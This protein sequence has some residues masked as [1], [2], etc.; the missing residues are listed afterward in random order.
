MIE[1]KDKPWTSYIDQIKLLESR[2]MIITDFDKAITYL[3]RIGY[4]RLSGYW[5]VFLEDESDNF[6]DK[7]SFKDVIS[8]YIFDKKLRLLILDALERIEISLRSEVSYMLGEFSPY[9]HLEEEYLTD[10]FTIKNLDKTNSLKPV[11]KENI[12]KKNPE[13]L[14]SK[15]EIWCIKQKK[16]IERSKEEYIKHNLNNYG[17]DLKIW[18]ACQVWDFGLMSKFYEGMLPCYK[19]RIA[20]KYQID[21]GVTL[22]SWLH[23]MNIVR[24][25]CAHHGRLWNRSLR[26]PQLPNENIIPWVKFFPSHNRKRKSRVFLTLCIIKHMIDT[27]NPDSTWWNRVINLISSFPKFDYCDLDTLRMGIPEESNFL[28]PYKR[29]TPK[30]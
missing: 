6:I 25:I 21:K 29:K 17:K 26:K 9:A 4:Y 30:Q 27:I 2:G 22:Q 5:D 19:N 24:N 12:S 14:T 10:D 13:Y 18:V 11:K 8:I 23:V 1:I 20:E 16:L 28:I 3:E 15:Y 7:T